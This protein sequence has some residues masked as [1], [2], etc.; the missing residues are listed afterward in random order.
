MK[1]YIPQD[2]RSSIYTRTRSSLPSNDAFLDIPSV[3]IKGSTLMLKQ[4][5]IANHDYKIT[6]I[7]TITA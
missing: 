1:C 2:L 6:M 7:S 4:V 3:A 5:S